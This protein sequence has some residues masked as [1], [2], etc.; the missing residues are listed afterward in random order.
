MHWLDRLPG[1]VG[2]LTCHPGYRDTSLVGRD[3]TLTDGQLERRTG[4]LAHLQGMA[5]TDVCRRA[6]W[7]HISPSAWLADCNDSQVHAA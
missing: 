2:E 4:E 6:G 3:C 7:T 1:N 5:F